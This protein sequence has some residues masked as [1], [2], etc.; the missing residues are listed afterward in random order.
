[1]KSIK[2]NEEEG[3]VD[4]A[5][6]LSL[7]CDLLKRL[8]NGNRYGR[9]TTYWLFN[10]SERPLAFPFEQIILD[11]RVCT[12]NINSIRLFWVILAR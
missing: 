11:L 5:T 4:I 10:A 8:R 3:G 1:M 9:A 2:E 7:T 6:L 12:I